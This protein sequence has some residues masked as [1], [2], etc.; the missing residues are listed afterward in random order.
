MNMRKAFRRS[1]RNNL[2]GAIDNGELRLDYQPQFDL[3]S[4]QIV[5][6]EA[7]VRWDS[8]AYGLVPP[9]RFLPVAEQAGIIMS[10]GQWVL[11]GACR[12][13]LAWQKSGLTPLPIAINLSAAQFRHPALARGV[14]DTIQKKGID[15]E[16]VVLE[17]DEDVIMQDAV[18]AART[19]TTLKD[20]GVQLAI[21]QFGTGHLSL[22]YLQH[23]PVDILKIDGTFIRDL[24]GGIGAARMVDRITGLGKILNRRV[25]GCGVEASEQVSFLRTRACDT[26]QGHYLSYPLCPDDLALLLASKHQPRQRRKA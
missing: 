21:D 12:Q 20:T 22:P 16:S 23:V 7:L 19:L 11:S 6:A 5:G 8:P 10:I 9:A 14:R 2:R 15:P 17:V 13:S 4:G 24:E 3:S 18:G 26:A 25:V 1:V